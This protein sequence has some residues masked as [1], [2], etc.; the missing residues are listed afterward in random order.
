MGRKRLESSY[1]ICQT[2]GKSFYP[3]ANQLGQQ[4]GK[5]NRKHCFECLPYTGDTRRGIT[6]LSNRN[7]TR[8][9]IPRCK[10][11]E[12]ACRSGDLQMCG[13]CTH[14]YRKFELKILAMRYMKGVCNRCG[15][16]SNMRDDFV[17][18]DYHH[19][20]DQVKNFEIGDAINR[21][22]NWC[23]IQA[24]LDFCELLCVICH[25]KHHATI[26]PNWFLEL[27]SKNTQTHIE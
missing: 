18:F 24:E 22:M 11:C 14:L 26:V 19:V 25:R 23:I 27:N 16:K 8:L 3:R 5:Y 20:D 13:A 1:N 4:V 17:L 9:E 7:L 12:R 6:R 2:C 15:L 10:V 21:L